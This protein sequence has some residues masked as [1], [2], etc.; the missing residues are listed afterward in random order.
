MVNFKNEKKSIRSLLFIEII[1]LF[2]ISFVM[3]WLKNII[4]GF[5][6]LVLIFTIISWLILFLLTINLYNKQDRES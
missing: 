3:L 4:V 5:F 6:Y 1:L 2:I